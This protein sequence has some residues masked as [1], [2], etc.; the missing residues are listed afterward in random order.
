MRNEQ[1]RCYAAAIG[2]H[3]LRV[4]LLVVGLLGSVLELAATL[5][6]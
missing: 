1:H 2:E 5:I 6:E 3:I 4:N